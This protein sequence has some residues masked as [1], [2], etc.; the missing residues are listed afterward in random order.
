[1]LLFRSE[2][3]VRAWCAQRGEPPGGF[4]TLEQTWQLAQHWYARR[5]EPDFRR[6][7]RDEGQAIFTHIGLVGPFWQLA[8]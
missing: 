1:M 6:Y 5:L 8:R 2:E 3:H 4:M 7:T